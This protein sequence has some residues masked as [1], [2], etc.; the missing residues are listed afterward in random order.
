MSE[1]DEAMVELFCKIAVEESNRIEPDSAMEP[2]PDE[3]VKIRATLERFIAAL[4]TPVPMDHMESAPKAEVAGTGAKHDSAATLT[5]RGVFLNADCFQRWADASEFWDQQPYGTRF[6]WGPNTFDYIHRGILCEAVRTIADYAVSTPVV[7]PDTAGRAPQFNQAEFDEMIRKG[8]IA[9]AGVNPSDLRGAPT[10]TAA[11]DT[12]ADERYPPGYVLAMRVLQSDLYETLDDIERADCDELIARHITPLPDTSAA[13]AYRAAFEQ[14]ATVIDEVRKTAWDQRQQG[15]QHNPIYLED[16]ATRLC[17]VRDAIFVAAAPQGAGNGGEPSEDAMERALAVLNANVKTR[18]RNT[19]VFQELTITA[20]DLRCAIAAVDT[21]ELTQARIDL[22]YA[23]NLLDVALKN[24]TDTDAELAALK[25]SH[26]G[27]VAEVEEI[28]AE[29]NAKWGN[30]TFE[31]NI[32][33]YTK[34]M[35]AAAAKSL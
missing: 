14:F 13:P 12:G 25:A 30:Q 28:A 33:Y 1:V 23:S 3:K 21:A 35:L 10:L 15:Q 31:T 19:Q 7:E 32:K 6:Y 8:T 26:A 20:D 29:L 2:P 27:L 5:A 34:R 24:Y 11:P 18:Y 4:S 9:W 22:D 17:V 16:L